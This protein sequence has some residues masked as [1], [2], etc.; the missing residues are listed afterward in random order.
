VFCG[1]AGGPR[2]TRTSYNIGV[3]DLGKEEGYRGK[4]K[5]VEVVGITRR[6][7]IGDKSADR[8]G[9]RGKKKVARG[10]ASEGGASSV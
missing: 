10:R 5:R 4:F 1:R 6:N 2:A 3:K 9:K 7:K 8:V